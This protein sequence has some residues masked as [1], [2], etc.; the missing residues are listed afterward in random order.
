MTI[1]LSGPMLWPKSGHPDKLVV[2]LHG[3]GSDGNDLI[4]LAPHFAEILPGALFVAP[5]APTPCAINPSGYQWFPVSM[6][7]A[8][9]RF[10]G[11]AKGRAIIEEFLADIWQQ[12]GLTAKDTI[13][14]GFSQGGMIALDSGLGL[15]SPLA[16]IIS[17][18]GGL[19]PTENR[20]KP[21]IPGPPICLIHGDHDD[22]VPS[23]FSVATDQ[24]LRRLGYDVRLHI[25]PGSPHTIAPDG[26]EFALNFI[27]GLSANSA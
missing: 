20:T 15:A 21:A 14:A 25:S 3:Y 13:L 24:A 7:L 11:I 10:E 23:E 9:P 17:F 26:L 22:V 5:N 27:S 18:S 6:D 12:S 4:G 19:P 2:L 1:K 8:Q 16:G